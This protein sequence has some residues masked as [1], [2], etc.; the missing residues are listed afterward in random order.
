MAKQGVVVELYFSGMWNTMP[1]YTR[2]SIRIARQR[3]EG[4]EPSPATATLTL[5]GFH[6]PLS[7]LSPLFGLAGQNTPIRITLPSD[8]RFYGEVSSWEPRRTVD[9]NP[10]TGRG[11]AW[12]A[13]T[14]AGILRRLG[15]GTDPFRTPLTRAM[16]G[17]TVGDYRAIAHWAMEDEQ[18]ATQLASS[19][20]GQPAATFLG[21][22][23]PAGYAGFAGSLPLPLLTAGT[24]TATMP[25]YTDTG[26]W[27]MQHAF[28]IPSTFTADGDLITIRMVPGN[29][30]AELRLSYV[31]AGP[32]L[33]LTAYNAAGG[34]MDTDDNFNALAYDTDYLASWTDNV[35]GGDH[36]VRF[37]LWGPDGSQVIGITS[38][39]DG[40][41]AGTNGMP[42]SLTARAGTGTA[43]WVFGQLGLYIDDVLSSPSVGPNAQA[44][45]GFA[46]E[47]VHERMERLCREEGIPLT[48]EG[49]TSQAMGVQPQETLTALFAEGERTDDGTLFEPRD[50]YGLIYRCRLQ[51]YNRPVALVLDYAAQEIGGEL[52]PILD[53][54]ASR[55]D[56]TVSRRNGGSARAVLGSGRL[57]VLEPPDGIGRYTTRVDVNTETDHVLPQHASWHLY[58]GTVEGV[59]YAKVT[60]DLDAKPALVGD[61]A[62][63][64]VGDIIALDNLPADEATGRV[65]LMVTGYVETIGSHRRL[66]TFDCIPAA[67]YDVGVW[68]SDATGSRWGARTT[69]LAEDLTTAETAADVNTGTDVWATTASHPGLFPAGGG[70]GINVDIGGLTY[71][72]TAITGTHPNLTLTVVRL[73]AD[74]A[75]STGDRV[76]VTDT[77]R[78]GM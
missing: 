35:Q 39:P 1:T 64:D 55:N 36:L 51:R 40:P 45:G 6:N 2:D 67:Q 69:V 58:K 53:D 23:T 70:A 44:A 56:V 66:I 63:V 77:F 19:L 3:P 34:V 76:W 7:P 47:Q 9:H 26:I 60:V 27:Q 8:T 15:Q 42:Q 4:T 12:T 52:A 71:L 11:D 78:W 72:C 14:A 18:A 73:A 22:V 59:R 46:G 21:D 10:A 29:T 32:N 43:G 37:G 62:A 74:K 65:L 30:V 49:S 5:E 41:G 20:S 61:A 54:L 24:I 16:I 17:D 33:R 57:S 28:R 38:A 48:V 50:S 31:H 75:H 25:A 68:G 13:I